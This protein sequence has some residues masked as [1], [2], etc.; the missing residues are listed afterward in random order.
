VE[1]AKEEWESVIE[2]NLTATFL[3]SRLAHPYMMKRGGGASVNLASIMG[4]SGG[5][6]PNASYA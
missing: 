6:F 2:L 3:C 1:L 4:L 5:I